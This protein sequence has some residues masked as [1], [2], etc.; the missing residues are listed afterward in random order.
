[1]S[2]L[3]FKSTILPD[4]FPKAFR[5]LQNTAAKMTPLRNFILSVCFEMDLGVS[6][7][8]KAQS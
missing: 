1:V 6:F 5:K 2:I 3:A 8:L 4:F 7:A